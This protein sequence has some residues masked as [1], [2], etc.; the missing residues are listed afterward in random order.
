MHKLKWIPSQTDLIGTHNTYQC[1]LHFIKRQ[2]EGIKAQ[3]AYIGHPSCHAQRVCIHGGSSLTGGKPKMKCK[4][5]KSMY[6]S[7]EVVILRF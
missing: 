4:Y 1:K 3:V 2:N 5:Y 6:I 7:K